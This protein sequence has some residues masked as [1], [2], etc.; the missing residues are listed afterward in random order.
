MNKQII[1]ILNFF[2]Y[3]SLSEGDSCVLTKL[4]S[5]EEGSNDKLSYI[6]FYFCDIISL[7]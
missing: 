2:L 4:H 5:K 1:C 6:F 3:V 7:R